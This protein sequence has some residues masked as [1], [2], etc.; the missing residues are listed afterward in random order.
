MERPWRLFLHVI[1]N[2]PNT[3]RCS[4]GTRRKWYSRSKPPWCRIQVTTYR[5]LRIGRDGHW[6]RWPSRPIQS[7]LQSGTCTRRRAYGAV[8]RPGLHIYLLSKHITPNRSNAW[9]VQ[10]CRRFCALQITHEVIQQSAMPNG[11]SRSVK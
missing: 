1:Q 6:S 5:R 8:S 9:S 11:I 7:L 2:V 4:I 10:C 3:V